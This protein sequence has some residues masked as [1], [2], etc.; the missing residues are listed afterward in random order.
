MVVDIMKI[1][2]LKTVNPYFNDIWNRIKNFDVRQ[3][4]RN[5]KIGEYLLLREYDPNTLN[6]YL[7]RELLCRIFYIFKDS[8]FLKKGFIIMGIHIIEK[9][10]LK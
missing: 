4:D 10:R 5:F 3:N 1:H 7:F 6:K 8:K 9:V 2:K